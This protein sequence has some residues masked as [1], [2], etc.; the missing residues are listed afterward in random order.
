MEDS[1]I[2]DLYWNR[3]EYAIT[4][5]ETKYGRYLTTVALNIL[6]NMEDSSECVNDTY[7]GAW[8][9]IPPQRPSLLSAYLAKITRRISIDLYRR[10]NAEKRSG[11]N[12]EASLEELC[13]TIGETEDMK[14]DEGTNPVKDREESLRHEIIM[15]FIA[16]LNEESRR[17]FIGRYFYMDSVKDIAGYLHISESKVKTTLFRLRQDLK[18]YLKKEGFFA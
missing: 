14:A 17:L 16:G 12:Y 1:A 6:N 5:T 10:K 18:E 7:L 3:D 9:S 4:E 13:E 15:K 8:N 2:V 11:S